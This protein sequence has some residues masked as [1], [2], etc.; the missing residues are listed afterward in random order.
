[1]IEISDK[2]YW[3][4]CNFHEAVLY[5]QFLEIDGKKD[6]RLFKKSGEYY[7]HVNSHNLPLIYPWH[8]NCHSWD[9]NRKLNE[10]FMCIPVRDL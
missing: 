1:M 4:M 7:K 6:Y 5:V 8:F 10:I 3:I 2:K 9:P